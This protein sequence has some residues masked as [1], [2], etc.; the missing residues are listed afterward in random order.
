VPDDLDLTR[1]ADEV[2]ARLIDQAGPRVSFTQLARDWAPGEIHEQGTVVHHQGGVWQARIR[3]ASRPSAETGE[4]LLLTNGIRL[5]RSYQDREDPRV[6]GLMVGLT[7]G[8]TIDLP[9]RLALPVHRG[10]YRPGAHYFEGDEVEYAGATFRALIEAP[11]SPDDA[12]WVVVAAR[13]RQGIAGERGPV[14]EVGPPGAPG[15][16]GPRGFTGAK[17]EPGAPGQDGFGIAG[18]EAVPGQPGFVRVV[19]QDGSITNPVDVSSMRFV[20]IYQPGAD[21][22]RGDIV[23]LGFALWICVEP[24]GDV[25]TATSTKWSLYLPSA[26]TG[27]SGGGQSGGGTPDL[28]TLDARYVNKAGGDFMAGPLQ[29]RGDNQVNVLQF[30]AGDGNTVFSGMRSFARLGEGGEL[31][32]SVLVGLTMMDAMGIYPGLDGAPHVN[33]FTQPTV[34]FDVANKAYVDAQVGGPDLP[35]LD[36]R[37]LRLAGGTM[38]GALNFAA[39]DQGIVWQAG[40]AVAYVNANTLVFRQ[41]AGNPGVMIEDNSGV[42]GSRRRILVEGEGGISQGDADTRY[43]QL[44]TGG[45]VRGDID[46]YALSGPDGDIG[47]NLGGRGGGIH[48]NNG[49][50]LRRGGGG[51]TVWIEN[52]DGSNLSEVL[53]RALGVQK[54]GDI[55]TG[56]LLLPQGSLAAPS[57]QFGSNATGLF[58][59]ANAL[60]VD[61]AGAIT[62]QWTTTLAMSTVPL[63]MVNNRILNLPAPAAASDAANRQYV[64]DAI[65]A[66]TAP[67]ALRTLVYQP[68]EITISAAALTFL[69]VNFPMPAGGSGIRNIGVSI[70]PIFASTDPVGTIW[71]LT[72]A[73]NLIALVSTLV[74]YKMTSNSTGIFRTPV[75]LTAAV[76]ASSGTVRVLLSIS[77]TSTGGPLIQVGA[78]GTIAP[79]MRTLVSVQDLGPA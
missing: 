38:D 37:Y 9:F 74:A 33:V 68:V 26:E 47:M 65:A 13:G 64:D 36:A 69:D 45:L 27:I 15:E 32:F 34:P 51:E 40:L 67:T 28:P 79:N 8:K 53:T 57:L 5:V 18:V 11:G 19:L 77:A 16:I 55:M 48:W 62:W 17:G 39:T 29:L 23:R 3:T 63:S 24:T 14:G 60:I 56:P 35:T 10:Q 75:K 61:L 76:D 1:F 2:A 71:E 44:A 22:Q 4:W 59:A 58:S 43:L 52:N 31:T 20:G 21:Y 6:F 73:S 78:G 50:V 7:G 54:A 41:T 25:P 46:L 12:G 30:A 42:T 49:V 72:Y 66:A 70:D